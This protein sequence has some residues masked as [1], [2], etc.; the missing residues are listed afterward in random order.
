MTRTISFFVMLLLGSIGYS[1]SLPVDMKDLKQLA[2][3]MAGEFSSG[4]QAKA[5]TNY[6]HIK[7]W[8]TPILKSSGDGYWLYV[9]QAGL[10]HLSP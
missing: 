7:L 6:Y 2:G 3:M 5:D 8:M 9:E 1:Q 10:Q 4:E